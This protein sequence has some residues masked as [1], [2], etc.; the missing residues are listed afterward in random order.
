[1]IIICVP[2]DEVPNV[3]NQTALGG[4]LVTRAGAERE[5]LNYF[6]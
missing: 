6:F 3:V 1:M 2:A 5:N 4:R